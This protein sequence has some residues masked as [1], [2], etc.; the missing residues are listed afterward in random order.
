MF[1]GSN[2]KKTTTTKL[3]NVFVIVSFDFLSLASYAEYK[4]I[5]LNFHWNSFCANSIY[6]FFVF[7][8]FFRVR[9]IF[10]MRFVL[11]SA[12]FVQIF[13]FYPHNKMDS[14]L[15]INFFNLSFVIRL[16][17][18]F[19]ELIEKCLVCIHGFLLCVLATGFV[20]C[21]FLVSIFFFF[22]S[23]YFSRFYLQTSIV[24][25]QTHIWLP[26]IYLANKTDANIEQNK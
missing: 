24:V 8:F 9:V 5:S 17:F 22:F 13:V 11:L 1:G 12:L 14:T 26:L 7:F 3:F 21:D 23:F 6:R 10:I 19:I 25:H 20:I 2:K 4:W 15:S 18:N 16:F